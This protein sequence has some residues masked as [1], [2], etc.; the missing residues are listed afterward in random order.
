MYDIIIQSVHRAAEIL[1]LFSY[2]KPRLGISEIS[3]ALNLNKGTVQGLVR[4]LTRDGFLR[5]DEETRKY[6]LGLKIYELGIILGGSLEINQKASDPAYQ[7]AKRTQLLV[8]IAILD[9]HSALTTMK[10]YPRSVPFISQQFGPRVP[11]YGT[12]MGKALLAFLEQGEIDS[13]LKATKLV[14]YTSN[15][16]TR[17]D[18]LLLKLQETRR[19]GFSVNREE[20][21]FGS[22]A[23]G[24]PIYGANGRVAA[25]ISIVGNPDEVMGAR[26]GTLAKEVMKTAFEIS[27]LMGFSGSSLLLQEPAGQ[28]K[29]R[30]KG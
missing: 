23:I 28:R 27:R 15:T 6:Q 13:Y 3:R 29:R 26:K 18:K 2:Q 14:P 25:A 8:E 10:V 9:Q 22:A 24:A 1:N 19:K 21:L 7:L 16:I 5:Q 17:K 4:T 30:G 12:A 20:H 11:L